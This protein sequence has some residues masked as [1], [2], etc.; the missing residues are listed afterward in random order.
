MREGVAAAWGIHHFLKYREAV[1]RR[2]LQV[3]LYAGTARPLDH[4]KASTK[5]NNVKRKGNTNVFIESHQ[6][7]SLKGL[8]H[9]I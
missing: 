2:Q 7:R 1:S 5:Q 6:N 3:M 8:S 9:E 4:V